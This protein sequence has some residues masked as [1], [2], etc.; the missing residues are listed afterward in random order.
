MERSTA[1]PNDQQ[2]GPI[3][4]QP[5]SNRCIHST[6]DKCI[7]SAT[8]KAKYILTWVCIHSNQMTKIQT[9]YL[10]WHPDISSM[11][12]MMHQFGCS[13]WLH[14]HF[15]IIP[16]IEQRH[17]FMQTTQIMFRG[18]TTSNITLKLLL[19]FTQVSLETVVN[20]W[21]QPRNSHIGT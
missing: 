1:I 18:S 15:G 3:K 12:L 6:N 5:A 4:F 2:Q 9:S 16:T 8:T 14:M 20:I 21:I 13:Q 17:I 7:H 19:C 11:A 10:V